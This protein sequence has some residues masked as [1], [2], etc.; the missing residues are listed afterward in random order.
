MVTTSS[1]T[2]HRAVTWWP[3]RKKYFGCSSFVPQNL[4][5][6]FIKVFR[7]L[8][9]IRPCVSLVLLGTFDMKWWKMSGTRQSIV[10]MCTEPQI[11]WILIFTSVKNTF[12]GVLA[13]GI[14]FISV[15]LIMQFVV[16]QSLKSFWSFVFTVYN[17]YY[18]TV[19]KC[20]WAGLA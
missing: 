17:E 20:Y 19:M 12:C 2:V 10:L 7:K 3:S 15:C 14:V 13:N 18:Y 4:C 11:E 5:P 1:E 16:K 6:L 9:K 8:V